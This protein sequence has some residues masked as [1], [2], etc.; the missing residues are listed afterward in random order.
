MI[1]ETEKRAVRGD[2]DYEQCKMMLEHMTDS[3]S[4]YV[5]A[6]ANRLFMDEADVLEV[7]KGDM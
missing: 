4:M 2:N 3:A 6:I 1:N 7:I 5:E